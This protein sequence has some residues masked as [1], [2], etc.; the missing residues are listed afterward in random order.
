MRIAVVCPYALDHPG[1][2]QNVT[3]ELTARYARAGHDAWLV[4]PGEGLAFQPPSADSLDVRL[5]GKTIP[6]PIN[7]SKAPFALGPRVIGRTRDALVDADVVHLHEPFAPLTSLAGAYHRAA[8][9][10]GTFH[11][12]PTPRL[13]RVYDAAS[14][15][16]RR[17]ARHLARA[18]AVSERA[19][20]AVRKIVADPVVV[21]NGVDVAA[22]RRDADRVAERVVFVGRD[23]E[24]KGLHVLLAAWPRVRA[25]LEDAAELRVVGADGPD[26]DGISYLG[27]VDEET[28]RTA[29]SEAAI[30]CAPNLGGESF[31][32]VPLEGMAAGC[33]V[34]ASDLPAFRAVVG[35]AGVLVP[36]GDARA[37]A[38]AIVTLLREPGWARRYGDAAQR[39]AI[40]YDWSRV[41]DEYLQVLRTA[42]Q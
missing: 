7:K 35:D 26:G 1:G 42:H 8:P 5:V 4:A 18:T 19:A 21:P 6:V 29:L 3:V 12:S 38:S 20:H 33:A 34:V 22:Y 32:V 16:L 13:G 41:T 37:L 17:V 36:P 14:P 40:R 10:V 15:M 25:E 30:L 9:V 2:V 27:R 39:A 24:R 11:S 23:D 28:K 31:G